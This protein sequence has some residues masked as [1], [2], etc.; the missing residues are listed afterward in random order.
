MSTATPEPRTQALMERSGVT[1]ATATMEALEHWIASQRLQPGDPLPTEAEI[2]A[3]L[4]VSR[5][6]VREALRQL[7]ALDIVTVKHGSGAFVG[8]M[9]MKPFIQAMMLRYSI[10]PDSIE[11]LHQLISL[12]KILDRGIA[13]ELTTV[14][15][16]SRTPELHHIVDVMEE[17]AQQGIAF[18]AEDIAFHSG[19]LSRLD[20]LLVEQ[21]VSAM[22]EIH[23]HVSATLHASAP[24]AMLTTAHAHREILEALE[25]GDTARY[26]KA[27]DLHYAPLEALLTAH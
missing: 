9:S 14:F 23:T 16:G 18:T 15:S 26:L 24:E 12:R 21:M 4:G 1:R 2:I 5:S 7:Q 25:A 3:E 10:S 8:N 13:Q 27:V 19:L 20:N 11:A 6:S 17:K 22:W